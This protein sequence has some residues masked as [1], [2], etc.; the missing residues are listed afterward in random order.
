MLSDL[1]IDEGAQMILEL[2]VRP[3]FIHAG[4]PAVAGHI[5]RQDSGEPSFYALA[6]Q[7]CAPL[8]SEA[9]DS[10]ALG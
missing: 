1:R 2:C 5:G 10:T 7:R 3:F 4:Q 6:A 8:K 9:H